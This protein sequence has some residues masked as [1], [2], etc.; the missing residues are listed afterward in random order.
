MIAPFLA[1]LT[2]VYLFSNGS[3]LYRA[4][5]ES[6]SALLG[7]PPN[8]DVGH[9]SVVDNTDQDVIPDSGKGEDSLADA[10]IT[11]TKVDDAVRISVLRELLHERYKVE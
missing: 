8:I 4:S 3:H 5:D 11:T 1:A 2:V 6:T 7:S 9:I 10:A